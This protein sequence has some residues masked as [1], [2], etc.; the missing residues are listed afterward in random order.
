MR[1]LWVPRWIVLW[2]SVRRVR[3]YFIY[4][5]TYTQRRYTRKAET[6]SPARNVI[7]ARSLP[8]RE[9]GLLGRRRAVRSTV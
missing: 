9:N 6:L 7:V 3:V 5:H 4:I 2:L 8:I 1:V